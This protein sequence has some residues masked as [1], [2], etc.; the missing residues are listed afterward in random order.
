MGGCFVQGLAFRGDHG[1]HPTGRVDGEKLGGA[2]LLLEDVDLPKLIGD[3]A[4]RHDHLDDERS[5]KATA[6][7]YVHR[8]MYFNI[9]QLRRRRNSA[10]RYSR[11]VVRLR[12]RQGPRRRCGW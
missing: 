6:V 5:G 3:V 10:S 4:F 2:M 12:R 9:P 8:Y 11:G 7:Q 1:W